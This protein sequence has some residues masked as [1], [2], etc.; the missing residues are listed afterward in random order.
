MLQD[1]SAVITGGANGIGFSIA[2][3]F[4]KSGVSRV[5]ILDLGETLDLAKKTELQACN[6]NAAIFYAQCDITNKQQLEKVLRQ[7]AVQKMG[8]I[9]ILV[10]CA[11][12]FDERNPARCIATN[13][14]ALID[15]SMIVI[16]LM[17]KEKAGRGGTIVNISSIA[18]LQE[19]SCGAVYCASKSGVISFTKS[20]G[21][22]QIFEL[23]GVK[24]V[25]IC[26][27]ATETGM[28]SSVMAAN[29]SFP[30]LKQ[31][32]QFI[33]NMPLQKPSSVGRA[34]V[35]IIKEGTPGS[36]WISENDLISEVERNP[37]NYF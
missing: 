23:T 15:C 36:V 32:Q 24:M 4:L 33:Q 20:V 34:V 6:A 35:K 25:A 37:N 30:A 29:C 13:L 28:Y 27:G 26:P 19:F 1:Q 14:T 11:G 10:N 12:I 18:G 31:M 21:T 5:L 22:D 3:E 17:T 16:D 7:D 8:S 9:D 2:A